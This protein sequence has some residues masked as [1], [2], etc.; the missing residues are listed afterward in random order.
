MQQ[1]NRKKRKGSYAQFTRERRFMNRDE[2]YPGP[3]RY[4]YAEHEPRDVKPTAAYISATTR[5][6]EPFLNMDPNTPGM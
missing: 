1:F 6:I 3:G 4:F 5:S 2:E